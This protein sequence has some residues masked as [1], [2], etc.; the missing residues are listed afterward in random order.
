MN[1]D[2]NRNFS[3]DKKYSLYDKLTGKSELEAIREKKF[4]PYSFESNNFQLFTLIISLISFVILSIFLLIQDDRIITHLESLRTDGL[5]T[6][7]P[8]RFFVDDLL[9]FADREEIKCENESEILL[10]RSDCPLIVDIHSNYAKVKNNS[11]VITGLLIFS[12]LVSIFIFCS[13]I[14][15]GTRN[16]PTLKFDNQS[17]TPDQSVFWLLIPIVNFWRSFQVFRQLYLGSKPKHSNNLLL[18]I[19]T[20]SIVYYILILLWVLILVIF[21]IFNRRT[22]DFFWSRQNDI[23]YNLI[24]YY[25]ILFLSDIVLIVIGTLTIINI[26]VIN[27]FQNLRHKEVGIIVVDPKKRLKK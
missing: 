1:K 15:R 18:E 14:H 8:S 2:K 12:S 16:L 23:L 5:E 6:S 13:F 21:T 22:I 11:F 10:L 19:F 27:T 4:E 26:S 25:N 7:P 17:L 9:A 3:Q 20:S 24:D